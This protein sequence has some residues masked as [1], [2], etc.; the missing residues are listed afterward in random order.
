MGD[1]DDDGDADDSP[2]AQYTR[3]DSLKSKSNPESGQ[4][5]GVKLEG[6][7]TD[8]R[9]HLHLPASILAPSPTLPVSA[10]RHTQPHASSSRVGSSPSAQSPN[11]RKRVKVDDRPSAVA[12][13]IPGSFTPRPE[14]DPS[15]ASR[16]LHP[17]AQPPH[18][19]LPQHPYQSG[20]FPGF[21]SHVSATASPG[22]G[23]G[24]GG[25]Y[26]TASFPS[27][28]GGSNMGTPPLHL[29]QP[30]GT[31]RHP[32]PPPPPPP[33]RITQPHFGPSTDDLFANVFGPA[34]GSGF[35]PTTQAGGSS[36]QH[37][38]SAG[39]SSS[40]SW[41]DFL[42]GSSPDAP[43]SPR[44][45]KRSRGDVGGGGGANEEDSRGTAG[46]SG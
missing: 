39:D 14:S 45:G 33:P 42:S 9:P 22:N 1:D 38:H 19:P 43:H 21:I 46:G 29:L 25:L 4:V 35:A 11:P 13:P 5:A 34:G 16:A 44:T 18:H 17:R 30:Y 36:G 8:Y 26:T 32:P 12:S 40:Q 27:P 10:D 15:L 41:L 23:G 7:Q 28:A 3:Q 37:G 24:G 6:L 31:P 20:F 2:T